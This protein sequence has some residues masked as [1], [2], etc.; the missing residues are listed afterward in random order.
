MSVPFLPSW[1][2]VR[3][4]VGAGGRPLGSEEPGGYADEAAK[5][6]GLSGPDRIVRSAMA[7]SIVRTELRSAIRLVSSHDG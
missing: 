5:T 1:Q 4:V 7:I 3:P 2:C 6:V